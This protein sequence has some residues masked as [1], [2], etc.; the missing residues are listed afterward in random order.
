MSS[1]AVISAQNL[2][3]VYS[4]QRGQK[5]H[6][7]LRESFMRRLRHP[8]AR[9]E[10]EDFWAL[11]DVSFDIH[12]GDVVGI[13]GRNGAGKS[14]LLKILSRITAPSEGRVELVGRVGSLL[15]VGTGFHPELTGRENVFLNGSILGMRRAEIAKRYDEIVEFSGVQQFIDTPVKRYSSGMYVRLAFAVA[16]HLET[17]ILIVDEVL[18]VGDID[19][20]RKCLGKMQEV[21]GSGR[22]VLFVS[23]NMS[24]VQRLCRRAILL[25]NGKLEA[26]GNVDEVI[27][28]YLGHLRDTA[29]TAFSGSNP[30]R[31]GNGALR[32]TS[33]RL[34]NEI[35]RPATHLRSGR[36][37]TL[38]FAYQN[39]AG[40]RTANVFMTIYN[41]LGVACTQL[42]MSLN[43]QSARDLGATGIFRCKIPNVP[44]P[45]GEYRIALAVDVDGEHA[46]LIPNALVFSVESSTFFESARTPPATYC[47]CMIE[48]EWEHQPDAT[49]RDPASSKESAGTTA[50]TSDDAHPH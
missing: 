13:I 30:D 6:Q 28:A 17:E 50:T 38:E 1:D 18:A 29:A 7:T 41:Q 49:D 5:G 9:A 36:P 21:A 2:S 11:R 39:A 45:I 33:A 3:K 35:D 25:R 26:S 48:H 46:D 27:T 44:F 15:E 22:T 24:A 16:A 8:L 32:I 47:A 20:Q 42:D 19:F 10:R 37:G 31:L 40:V 14:T 23:H 4:I 12:G 43:H 34:L